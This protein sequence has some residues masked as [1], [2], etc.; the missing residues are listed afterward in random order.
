MLDPGVLAREAEVLLHKTTMTT[1]LAERDVHLIGELGHCMRI[2]GVKE[3]DPRLKPAIAFLFEG[4]AL[5]GSWDARGANNADYYTRYHA[6]MSAV[7]CLH[8]PHFRGF[9]PGSVQLSSFFKKTQK[10]CWARGERPIYAIPPDPLR[11]KLSACGVFVSPNMTGLECVKAAYEG[12]AHG[13]GGPIHMS[14]RE[15]AR[16]RLKGLV[17]WRRN[18][19]E[20]VASSYKD[21]KRKATRRLHARRLGGPS[22]GTARKSTVQLSAEALSERVDFEAKLSELWQGC[23]VTDNT[24][25]PLCG[26]VPVDLFLLYKSVSSKGGFRAMNDLQAWSSAARQMHLPNSMP[27]RAWRLRQLYAKYLGN[28]EV[29]WAESFKPSEGA[30]PPASASSPMEGVERESGTDQGL[31]HQ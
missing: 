29:L 1:A 31:K 3:T 22:R 6:A 23:G 20:A 24:L 8:T 26:D 28:F 15:R 25:L 2:F 19:P 12:S 14:V 21:G 5:D 13:Q 10:E 11:T 7:I 16:Q 9:G 18:N 30:T 27:D 4:Q 17:R